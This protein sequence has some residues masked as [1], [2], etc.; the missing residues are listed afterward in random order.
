[1]LAILSRP[2]H[3]YLAIHSLSSF[4]SVL[5]LDPQSLANILFH[6]HSLKKRFFFSSRRRH[7]IYIGDWSS[8][9]CSSDLT[10]PV[11]S[12]FRAP[13]LVVSTGVARS[14]ACPS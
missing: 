1:M 2:P 8:D 5:P 3:L 10:L 6:G 4:F 7:T 9:V 11:R 14:T 13:R 12:G